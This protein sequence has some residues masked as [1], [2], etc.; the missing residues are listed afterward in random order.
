[1]KMIIS[2]YYI[3][4]A[5]R[6]VPFLTAAFLQKNPGE[7]NGICKDGKKT[8]VRSLNAACEVFSQK[9]Y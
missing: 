9:G 7:C 1:M 4:R 2:I 6:S 5:N 3:A 8:R